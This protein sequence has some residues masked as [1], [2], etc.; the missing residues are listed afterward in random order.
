MLSLPAM[1][2]GHSAER[3]GQ[4][5]VGGCI[6]GWLWVGHCCPPMHEQIGKAVLSTCTVPISCREALFQVWASGCWPR[7]VTIASLL[8]GGCGLG[9]ERVEDGC[10]STC[11]K[12]GG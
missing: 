7:A 10:K 5:E 12:F 6:R 2:F 8:V 11:V 4:G 1:S 9:H 3:A